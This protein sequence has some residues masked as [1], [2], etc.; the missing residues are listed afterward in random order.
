MPSGRLFLK[1]YN[2]N[3]EYGHTVQF[4]KF[5]LCSLAPT[6]SFSTAS[7]GDHLVHVIN[8]P[9]FVLNAN[10]IKHIILGSWFF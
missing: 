6:P 2:S 7:T 3:E 1:K 9:M 8:L 10:I 4:E 5:A